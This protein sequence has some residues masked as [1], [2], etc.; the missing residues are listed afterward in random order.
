MT[1]PNIIPVDRTF[2]HVSGIA[3]AVILYLLSMGIFLGIRRVLRKVF[4]SLA[5]KLPAD[6]P[7]EDIFLLRIDKRAAFFALLFCA[8]AVLPPLVEAG[9]TQSAKD[10]GPEGAIWHLQTLALTMSLPAVFLMLGRS[11]YLGLRHD[12]P[13]KLSR[14]DTIFH[15]ASKLFYLAFLYAAFGVLMGNMSSSWPCPPS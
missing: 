14:T 9:F 15:S 4:R 13:L 5:L 8:A 12:Y 10:C 7:R 1:D 3:F 11:A 2:Q 6:A